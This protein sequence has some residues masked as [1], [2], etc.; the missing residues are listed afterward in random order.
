MEA[1]VTDVHTRSAVAGLRALGRAGIR[2]LAVGPSRGAAGLWSRYAAWGTTAPDV[3]RDP[4]AFCE[5]VAGIAAERGPLVLYP[6]QEEAMDALLGDSARLP[7]QA[8][9]PYREPQAVYTLR[10]KRSLATVARDAGLRVPETLATGTAAE[11]LDCEIRT[12]CA[13]KAALPEQ[14]LGLTHLTRSDDE[15]K[16]LLENLSGAA[17]LLVQELVEGPLM[18]LALVVD[19]AGKLVARFQQEA[20]RT[21]PPD[22]G[23]SRFAVSVPPDETLAAKAARMLKTAGYSGLAQLQFVRSSS[24]PMLVDVNP[25]FYGS[26]PLALASGVNLPAAWHAVATGERT[27]S[28]EPYRVGVG[29]RWLEGELLAAMKGAPVP[30]RS[31]RHVAGAMWASDDPVPAAILAGRA[32]GTRLRARVHRLRAG[33]GRWTR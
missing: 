5:T 8:L 30:V 25:R 13:V 27:P 3:T 9:L 2:T 24:A 28:P 20:T 29:Y 12:P 7:A 21:W 6:V 32:V 10:D 4:I 17:L 22:A 19:E 26:L 16:E 31:R 18:A 1:L 11:L 14:G 23:A 33:E 15:L